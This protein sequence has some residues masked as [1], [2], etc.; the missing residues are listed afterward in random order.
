[1]PA[2]L[3]WARSETFATAALEKLGRHEEV[4]DNLREIFLTVRGVPVAYEN[5]AAALDMLSYDLNVRKPELAIETD[6]L[7]EE[8]WQMLGRPVRIIA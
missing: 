5:F 6:A 1:M 4:E 3:R 2:C 8:A 7:A